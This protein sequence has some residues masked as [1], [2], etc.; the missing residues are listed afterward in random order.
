MYVVTLRSEG[1]REGIG[2]VAKDGESALKAVTGGDF[3][4]QDIIAAGKLQVSPAP[5]GG[6]NY[7]LVGTTSFLAQLSTAPDGRLFAIFVLAPSA[8]Y[9]A[10]KELYQSVRDS[11]KTYTSV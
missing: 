2:F 6:F 3:A 8:E 4:L 10:H 5:G 1:S 7:E 11:F 9:E